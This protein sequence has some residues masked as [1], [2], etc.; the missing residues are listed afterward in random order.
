MVVIHVQQIIYIRMIFTC[1]NVIVENDMYYV[2]YG[3][4]RCVYDTN[5]FKQ[6]IYGFAA[7]IWNGIFSWLTFPALPQQGITNALFAILI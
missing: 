4:C 5:A 3:M 2:R 1:Q 6:I 7:Y